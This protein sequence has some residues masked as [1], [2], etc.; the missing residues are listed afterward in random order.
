MNM[1]FQEQLDPD[2]L[3]ALV[4]IGGYYFEGGIREFAYWAE[5]VVDEVGE[6]VRPHLQQVFDRVEQRLSQ[7]QVKSS[8]DELFSLARQYRS[9]EAY[10]ELIKF[11]ARFR[12]YAPFNTMLIH[13][14]MPGAQFVAPPHRWLRDYRRRIRT[15][16]RPLEAI[17]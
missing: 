12:W 9:S 4:D 11:I 6:W 3:S 8:L 16:A 13:I 2:R 14:Q 10:H 17:S 7:S 5:R 1:R 15:G